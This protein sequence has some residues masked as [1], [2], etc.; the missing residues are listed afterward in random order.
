MLRQTVIVQKPRMKQVFDHSVTH[1]AL[2]KN[3]N[4]KLLESRDLARAID[5]ADAFHCDDG[6]QTGPVAQRLEQSGLRTGEDSAADQ[7]SMFVI[8]LV[9]GRPVG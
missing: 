6:P 2:P 3:G 7:A 4:S 5:A 8:E 1:L 9:R